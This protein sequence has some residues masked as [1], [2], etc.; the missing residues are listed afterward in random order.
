MNGVS[1]V[2]I[3]ASRGIL[4]DGL[5]EGAKVEATRNRIAVDPS[6]LVSTIVRVTVS[7]HGAGFRRGHDFRVVR[8]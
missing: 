4:L 5:D 2:L 8:L 7:C 3:L 6:G 1:E